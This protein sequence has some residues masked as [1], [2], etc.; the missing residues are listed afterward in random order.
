MRVALV[1]EVCP[2]DS[3]AKDQ[4]AAWLKGFRWD[5][6]VTPTFRYP[7]TQGQAVAAVR[8]WL[9]T[10][11]PNV[12]AVVAY[13]RGERTDRLH[14]HAVIGGIGRH[15]VE[16]EDIR[17]SWRRGMIDVD[18]YDPK[19]GCIRYMLDFADDPEGLEFIGSPVPYRPRRRGGK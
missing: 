5:F 19:L 18:P 8:Q 9:A 12:Y 6:W 2:V 10:K 16:F 4:V 17:R 1:L 15:P 14:V 11:E 7:K 13:E 3:A